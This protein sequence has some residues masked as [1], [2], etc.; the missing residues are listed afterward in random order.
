MGACIINIDVHE[1][2]GT[3]FIALYFNGDKLTYS[4]SFEV[5]HIP[6]EI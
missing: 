6:K 2:I 5:K 4:D 3:H 1:S